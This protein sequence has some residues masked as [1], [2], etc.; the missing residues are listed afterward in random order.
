MVGT[1]SKPN[2]DYKCINIFKKILMNMLSMFSFVE[3]IILLYKLGKC[4]I[5][6][7]HNC[8]WMVWGTKGCTRGTNSWSVVNSSAPKCQKLA[9]LEKHSNYVFKRKNRMST[10]LGIPRRSPIQVLT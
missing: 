3:I 4:R 5:N 7:H 9:L 10:A 6:V 2:E 8:T 1:S